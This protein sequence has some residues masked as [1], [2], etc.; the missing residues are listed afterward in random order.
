LSLTRLTGQREGTVGVTNEPRQAPREAPG[1]NEARAGFQL[2][3]RSRD[4]D[5]VGH[6]LRFVGAEV[7]QLGRGESVSD[8][9]HVHVG[10]IHCVRFA[11]TR[12]LHASGARSNAYGFNLV[13]PTNPAGRYQ[14]RY[15]RA[16]QLSVVA[17]PGEWDQLIAGEAD[18]SLS[19]IMDT[20]AFLRQA[21]RV[22]GIDLDGKLRA[23]GALRPDT[24]AFTRLEAF[25]RRLFRR[26]ASQPEVLGRPEYCQ[27]VERACFGALLPAVTSAVA[28]GDESPAR[29]ASR[30]RLARR[31]IDFMTAHLDR[32]LTVEDLCAEADVSERTL[33]Y[34]FRDLFGVSPMAYFKAQKLHAVRLAL[35]AAARDGASVHDVARRWGFIHT[36]NFAADYF[37]QFGELP[38]RALA[39]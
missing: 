27:H 13:T 24:R 38:S 39:E 15:L 25:V 23:G 32:A 28:V 30:Y 19:V 20:E 18:E 2:R 21:E 10:A 16:G 37:R 22:Y 31:S 35:K 33:Q 5:E 8:L 6:A 11:A 29:A 7:R 12:A 17:P 9:H 34:A 26:V 1:P 14:S 3:L 36:G 4:L